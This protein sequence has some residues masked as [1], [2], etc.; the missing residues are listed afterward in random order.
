MARIL[1][2][3][4]ENKL[5]K[6]TKEFALN[7][8]LKEVKK[9]KSI[10]ALEWFLKKF[11]TK[12]ERVLVLRRLTIMGL[13]ENKKKYRSIKELLGVSGNTISAVKDIM[14]GY[15]YDKRDKRI[16]YSV[17]PK[18]KSKNRSFSKFPKYRTL[19]AK[20]RWRFLNNL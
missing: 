13:I 6:R 1:T 5:N 4:L 12:N 16:K 15:G 20:D 11:F 9:V 3:V 19:S 2:K 18:S 14:L 10:N 8:F 7:I 17:W